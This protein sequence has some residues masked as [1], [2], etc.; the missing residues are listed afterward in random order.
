MIFE[1]TDQLHKQDVTE[2]F[3]QLESKF[4]FDQHH[5]TVP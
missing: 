5:I 3:F 1:V 4:L 2:S